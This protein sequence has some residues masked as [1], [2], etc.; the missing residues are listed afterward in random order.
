MTGK[1]IVIF[2]V[3]YRLSIKDRLEFE[4]YI[5]VL[6]HVCLF[7]FVALCSKSR[8]M[9]MVSLTTLFSGLA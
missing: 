5:L 7:S 6:C 3:I 8:A 2:Q 4:S 9:V 1:V